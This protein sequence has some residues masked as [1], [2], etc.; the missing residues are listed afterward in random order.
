MYSRDTIFFSEAAES[1]LRMNLV[2]RRKK[3]RRKL[4]NS[5]QLNIKK[6]TS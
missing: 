4:G 5:K 2:K 3:L 6:S 1:A